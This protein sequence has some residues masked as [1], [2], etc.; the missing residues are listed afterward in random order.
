MVDSN[1][2][3][4]LLLWRNNL[5]STHMQFHKFSENLSSTSICQFFFY[6]VPLNNS[7]WLTGVPCKKN[8][9]EVVIKQLIQWLKL[10]Y[11][12]SS[13]VTI[14][15]QFK[16]KTITIIAMHSLVNMGWDTKQETNACNITILPVC[17]VYLNVIK[18]LVLCTVTAAS[19]EGMEAAPLICCL[20]HYQ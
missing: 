4:G 6:C 15:H 14:S 16:T 3:E 5:C 11:A 17:N 19:T 10:P 13:H 9:A 2:W 7:N 1:H 8:A 18:S 20:L 12:A